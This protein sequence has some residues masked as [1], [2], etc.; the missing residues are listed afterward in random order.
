MRFRDKENRPS[1]FLYGAN[2]HTWDSHTAFV[3]FGQLSLF[4][5]C[6]TWNLPKDSFV[7]SGQRRG[8]L[9]T[10]QCL[11]NSFCRKAQFQAPVCLS[12]ICEMASPQPRGSSTLNCKCPRIFPE[13][14]SEIS[15]SRLK[16]IFSALQNWPSLCLYSSLSTKCGDL[17]L[18]KLTRA[19]RRLSLS[20]G[21]GRGN[22]RSRT[23]PLTPQLGPAWVG[24]CESHTT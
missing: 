11:E 7:L 6:S 18:P 4:R 20:W 14:G 1:P 5:K 21:L 8:V 2:S 23:F 12:R 19:G 17:A 9:L 16:A 10:K 22:V 24:P 3:G 15:F 13:W